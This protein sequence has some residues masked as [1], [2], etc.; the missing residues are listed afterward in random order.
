MPMNVVRGVLDFQEPY[1]SDLSELTYPPVR[2]SNFLQ[3]KSHD[4]SWQRMVAVMWNLTEIVRR[5]SIVH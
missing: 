5:E 4:S 3:V 2:Q 1:S